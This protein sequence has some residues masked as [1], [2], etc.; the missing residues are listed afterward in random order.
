MQ[1]SPQLTYNQSLTE[2][3]KWADTESEWR[4]REMEERRR[5]R[6]NIHCTFVIKRRQRTIIHLRKM[7]RK[8]RNK[9][10]N[11]TH[12]DSKCLVGR[13][14]Q[15]DDNFLWFGTR[16]Y[17]SSL[18]QCSNT[19][20]CNSAREERNNWLFIKS[21]STTVQSWLVS[22]SLQKVV[23]GRREKQRRATPM[24]LTGCEQVRA[25]VKKK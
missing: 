6:L 3:G 15:I 14:A 11:A 9:P 22:S 24:Q 7:A 23:E 12:Y 4:K 19:G 5:S 1:S 2:W 10:K 21:A 25:G 16:F 20:Q 17:S 18:W 13:S 8:R